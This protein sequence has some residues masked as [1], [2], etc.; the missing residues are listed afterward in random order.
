MRHKLK[1]PFH[2]TLFVSVVFYFICWQAIRMFTSIAWIDTL[3]TYEPHFVPFYIGISGAI[4]TLMGL[5]L[6]W[7]MWRG[8]RGTRLMFVAASSLY[9][10]WVWLDRLFVQ[11]QMRADWPFDLVLT[12]VLY[13]FATIIVL[14]PRNKIY[15]ERETYERES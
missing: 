3:E 13:I 1:L 14:D 5:F 15:F 10:I 4:W 9:T 12:I 11:A 2:I 7:S 6:I 8:Q